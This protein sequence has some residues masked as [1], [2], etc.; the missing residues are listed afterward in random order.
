MSFFEK[1]RKE[2]AERGIDPARLPPGQ[3]FTDRFPVLHAGSVPDYGGDLSDW[4]FRLFGLVGVERTLSWDELMAL[5]SADVTVDI[6]CVTKWSKFDT[7]W[8]GIPFDSVLELVDVDPTVTHVMCHSEHGFTANIPLD[9]CRGTDDRGQPRALL[10]HHFG[11][12]PLEP[13]HGYPLRFFVP[14]LYFWKSAKWLRGLELMAGDSPGFWE[15]NGYHLYG[16]PFREQR[17]WGD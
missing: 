12:V 8:T 6:H 5:P 1:N 2:L 16:D 7:V 13:D 3:Y 10:A 15:Q 11:G 17:Y 14:H 4:T 9:D